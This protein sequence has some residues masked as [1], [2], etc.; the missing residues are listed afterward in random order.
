MILHISDGGQ[1][2]IEDSIHHAVPVLGVSYV[3]SMDHYLNR[4]EEFECGLNTYIDYDNT[5]E[6][7]RKVE[8]IINE[9]K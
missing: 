8:R 1:R 4:L 2:N 7:A 3:S 6:L 5:N 9:K